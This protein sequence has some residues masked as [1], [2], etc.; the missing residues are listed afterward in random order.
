MDFEFDE[1]V[2]KNKLKNILS[3]EIL[4]ES[5]D[6]QDRTNEIVRFIIKSSK[7]RILGGTTHD[8]KFILD[9][10][11]EAAE[12]LLVESPNY[13]VWIDAVKDGE[14][15]ESHLFE[16]LSWSVMQN[17]TNSVP[18]GHRTQMDEGLG[19]TSDHEDMLNRFLTHCQ[20]WLGVEQIPDIRM[21]ANREGPMT[22]G[23][24]NPEDKTIGA[25]AGN[26]AFVDALR[27]VA[28][29]LVHYKQDIEGRL[30]GEIPQVG[31]EI[32]DEANAVA[33]QMVKSFGMQR[34]NDMI[35]EM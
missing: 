25:L 5:T 32:E 29:E 21:M 9:S 31:G 22:T 19:Y 17:P 16:N 6:P 18:A 27:T 30:G 8:T 14:V 15:V 12:N 28:H 3:E 1:P 7:D 35:Y 23:V 2:D 13:N 24:Y 33:G 10:A 34:D 4:N 20:E 11:K 26:R